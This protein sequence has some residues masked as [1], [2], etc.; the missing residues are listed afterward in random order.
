[1]P[2]KKPM[3]SS[4]R[5]HRKVS[6][7]KMKLARSQDRSLVS[8]IAVAR[9]SFKSPF[10]TSKVDELVSRNGGFEIG[11]AD[12]D[13]NDDFGEIEDTIKQM[14]LPEYGGSE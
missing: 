8:K 4:Q 14:F 11:C 3:H 5:T 10:D 2:K 7:H 6:G 12:F 9:K 13:T 1:M